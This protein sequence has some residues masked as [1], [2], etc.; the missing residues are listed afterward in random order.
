MVI[1]WAIV[2]SASAGTVQVTVGNTGCRTKQLTVQRLWRAMPGVRS[3]EIVPRKPGDAAN[4]RVF[5]V[6]TD[7]A[8]PEQACLSR[9]L[10]RRAERYPIMS[11]RTTS[12]V[13]R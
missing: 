5:I 13:T 2:A 7:G 12:S 8:V 4:Q 1:A 10:G 9:A 3:V 11:L 6:T